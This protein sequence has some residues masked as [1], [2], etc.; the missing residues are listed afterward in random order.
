MSTPLQKNWIQLGSGEILN[1]DYISSVETENDKV[2]FILGANL[3][4]GGTSGSNAIVT[5]TEADATA[6][7]ALKQKVIDYLKGQG[8]LVEII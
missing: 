6:A 3:R 5:R 1:M 8:R 4:S 2:H 7:L